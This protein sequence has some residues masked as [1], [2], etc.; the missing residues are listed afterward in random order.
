MKSGDQ[1]LRNYAFAKRVSS[2]TPSPTLAMNARAQ[3][4]ASQGYSVINLSVGEP[5]FTTPKFIDDAA[6]KAIDTGLASFY[7]PTL[8]I[9]ELRTAIANHGS[10]ID[11]LQAANVAVTASAKL[12]LYALMQILVSDGEKVV[13]AAPYWVSYQEQVKL[14]QGEFYP[15]LPHNPDFKLT[16][17]ELE[18][19]D[20]VPKVVIVNNPTNPTGA[21]Y[22]AAEMQSLI[23]WANI[24]DAFLIVDEI[25]GKLVYNETTFTSVLKLASIKNQKLIVVDGVSKAYAMTGWRIGWVLADEQIIAQLGNVLDHITSN[26]TAVSQY[27]ALAAVNGDNTSVNQMK[28]QFEKRLN[29]TWPQLT[30][31]PG[32]IF[33]AK[34]QG[35]FYCFMKVDPKVLE[36]KGMKNTTELTLDILEKKH[37]ALAAG[38]GFGL[39]GFL[40]LS[41]AK[42]QDQINEAIK[43]LKAYFSE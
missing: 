30:E 43:R 19:L 4:L 20:F 8:G 3:Q 31:I 23:K 35:A 42:K 11:H 6:K 33:G 36:R 15:I 18:K 38:E 26:P 28:Q 34:P 14:A 32:L 39:P 25:Y 37:V 40:R 17:A 9:K 29:A 2:I 21:V 16:T 24:N 12:A 22:S 1:K 5:D 10:S 27:A 13:I 7:T 41:Y